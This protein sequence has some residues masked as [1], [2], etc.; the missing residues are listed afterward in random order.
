MMAA[1]SLLCL[2]CIGGAIVLRGLENRHRRTG[3][4]AWD[5][6]LH[7]Y[8][9]MIGGVKELNRP[10]ARRVLLSFE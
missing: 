7:V 6:V 9:M 8:N 2:L 4:E 3:R 1:T 10:L 5:S